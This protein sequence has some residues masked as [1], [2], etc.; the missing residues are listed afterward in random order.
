M[1]L[2][3]VFITLLARL[4]FK[5]VHTNTIHLRDMFLG[6]IEGDVHTSDNGKFVD[7]TCVEYDKFSFGLREQTTNDNRNNQISFTGLIK[8]FGNQTSH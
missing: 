8:Y 1:G 3:E 6:D 4:V 2:V 5:C 7:E